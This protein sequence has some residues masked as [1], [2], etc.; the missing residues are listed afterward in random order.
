MKSWLI[1]MFPEAKQ[2]WAEE[3]SAE[4]ARVMTVARVLVVAWYLTLEGGPLMR[5]VLMT[6]SSVNLVAG[7]LVTAMW[8]FMEETPP[9]VLALGLALLIQGGYTVWLLV[10]KKLRPVAARLL[11]VGETLALL[12]GGGGLLVA[13]VNSIGA[14]DPEYGPLLVAGLFGAHALA[15]LHLFAV[16]DQNVT[17]E[18]TKL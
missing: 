12:V 3:L 14:V 10:G 1:S 15:G 18:M 9:V 8:V 7:L 17:R 11:I 2:E 13:I 5:T 6:L 16:R 4:D